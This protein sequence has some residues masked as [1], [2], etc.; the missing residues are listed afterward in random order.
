MKDFKVIGI[1][2]NKT[3]TKTLAACLKTLGYQKHVSVQPDLLVKFRNGHLDDIFDVVEKNQSFEDWPYPLMYKEL[4]FRF[5]DRARYILTKRIN[6]SAWLDSLKQHCLRTPP[7]THLR[8]LAY[9]YNYPH[10][11]EDYHLQFYDRHNHDV[12]E[13]FRKHNAEHLLLEISWDSGDRWEKLCRFLGKQIPTVPFPHENMSSQAI[14]EDI[15]RQN[16]FLINR[17]LSILRDNA[18][19]NQA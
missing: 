9:G 6:G 19:Q 5:G 3:G 13:L 16:Q 12:I 1:G 15:V 18:E 2:L 10:G 4:F 7:D 17:Q 11:L 14:P 8:F